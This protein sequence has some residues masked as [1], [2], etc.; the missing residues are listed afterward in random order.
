ME[1][2]DESTWMCYPRYLWLGREWNED[3]Q[4]VG[5]GELTEEACGIIAPL[6]P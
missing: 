1:Y 4:L 2:Y 3:S 6:L 5:R